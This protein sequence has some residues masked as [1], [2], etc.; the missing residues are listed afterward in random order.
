MSRT[1]VVPKNLPWGTYV[2]RC[3]DGA[4]LSD[5]DGNVLSMDGFKGDLEAMR[6]MRDAATAL[7]YGDGKVAFLPGSRK[8]SHSE[9]EDQME[10]FIEGRPIPGDVE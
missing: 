2:W 1:Q 8:I 6:K 5:D 4:P 7:G 3:A 10:A 9:W